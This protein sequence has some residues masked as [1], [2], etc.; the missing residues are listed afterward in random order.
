MNARKCRFWDEAD[1]VRA[2]LSSTPASNGGVAAS[3]PSDRIQRLPHAQYG[4][5]SPAANTPSNVDKRKNVV[6]AAALEQQ[7]HNKTAVGLGPTAASVLAPHWSTATV[8]ANQSPESVVL[9]SPPNL[10]PAPT[11]TTMGVL[12]PMS[13]QHHLHN[14]NNS[15][16]QLHARPAFPQPN[17]LI[18]HRQQN[19]GQH[20][21]YAANLGDG[22]DFDPSSMMGAI[23]GSSALDLGFAPA[24]MLENGENPIV[25]QPTNFVPPML[26]ANGVVGQAPPVNQKA[27]GAD[28]WGSTAPQHH[29]LHERPLSPQAY[30]TG[31]SLQSFM[32]MLTSHM[33]ERLN[34][35][36][37][38]LHPNDAAAIYEDP[39]SQRYGQLKIR[40]RDIN[41]A[42][43]ELGRMCNLHVNSD[44][45]QT[46]LGILHQAVEI[47]TQL[48]RQVRERNLN[49][50]AACLKNREA[51]KAPGVLNMTSG[52]S[53]AP[54][55]RR[56][57]DHSSGNASLYTASMIDSSSPGGS[58]LPC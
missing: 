34:T 40:V 2:L 12:N 38:I 56:Q 21:N 32:G 33:E 15:L 3:L 37:N 47:I 25:Q 14:V 17:V 18:N 30:Q 8:A 49:P 52:G 4:S 57:M 53:A 46:K 45:T 1:M 43:K 28:P 26:Y 27:Y 11:L 51:E 10:A 58:H 41:E 48:E 31:P 20:I 24:T 19:G 50:K 5:P 54:F 6:A 55:V 23:Y 16:P 29:H 44:K 13:H 35:A 42:F 9:V 7:F 36:I 22:A 39:S